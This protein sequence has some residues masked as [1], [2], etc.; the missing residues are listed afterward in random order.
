MRCWTRREG[1]SLQPCPHLP[2]QKTWLLA[3]A[4][5]C[6]RYQEEGNGGQR[7]P[8]HFCH[9]LSKSPARPH[10]LSQVSRACQPL[11]GLCAAL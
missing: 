1:G 6:S 10:S 9:P 5:P 11:I 7:A 8:A 4:Q 2:A 3:Q